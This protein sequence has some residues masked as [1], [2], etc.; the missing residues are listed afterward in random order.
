MMALPISRR[1]SSLAQPCICRLHR[2]LPDQVVRERRGRRERVLDRRQF[3][4]LRRRAR[5][6]AVVQVVAE[7]VLVVGVVPLVGL[8]GARLLG[9]RLVLLRLLGRLQVLGRD[10]LE[11]RVLHHLLVQQIGQLQRRHRQQLDRL[12]ERWR[13][14]ELLNEFGVELLRNRHVLSVGLFDSSPTGSR[15]RGKCA[16]L[17][18]P[19]P[20]FAAFRS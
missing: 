9:V 3:L 10:L 2:Q 18:R 4:D 15:H 17:P 1:L 5:A 14:D 12:L 20:G 13:K 11:Q 7:E 6:V 16:S 8:L 19:R